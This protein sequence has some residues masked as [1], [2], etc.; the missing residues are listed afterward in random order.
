MSGERF[1]PRMFIDWWAKEQGRT[2]QDFGVS[3]IVL[4]SWHLTS[5]QTLAEAV[6]AEMPKDW[7][8]GKRYPMYTGQIGG[9]SV[10]FAF[11]PV[12]A[13][14]TIMMMEEMIAS[15]AR[16]FIGFG[17]CGSL[18]ENLTV[19]SLIIPT[20][21]K[22]E[23]GTSPHYLDKNTTIG[24][25]QRLVEILEE[26]CREEGIKPQKG[27][28]WT[29]DA[30]YKETVEKIAKYHDEG[31]LGVDMETSAMY[32]LGHVREVSVCNL[33]VVSDELCNK[34]DPAFGTTRLREAAERARQVILRTLRK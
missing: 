1:T 32:T 29:T 19:G 3:P 33:L 2:V 17:Y 13:P 14:G 27:P 34:W 20:S 15:G 12:G 10:P 21:C 31:I 16:I 18:Q 6:G 7:F 26:S 30:P 5:I 8:Y 28:V 25:T 11:L 24:P 22:I 9:Q 4:V 23:E